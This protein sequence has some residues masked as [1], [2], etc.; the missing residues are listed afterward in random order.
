MKST[1]VTSQHTAV[2][3]VLMVHTAAIVEGVL[4]Q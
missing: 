3:S 4:R 1:I 2:T